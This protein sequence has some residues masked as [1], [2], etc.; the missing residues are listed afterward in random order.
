MGIAVAA[1]AYGTQQRWDEAIEN[2]STSLNPAQTEEKTSAD[3]PQAKSEPASVK[4]DKKTRVETSSLKP[5]KQRVIAKPKS[6]P[7]KVVKKQPT[8]APK[9]AP[10]KTVTPTPTPVATPAPKAIKPPSPPPA[11]L[12]VEFQSNPV[13]ARVRR[14][15]DKKVVGVTPFA[16]QLPGDS[17]TEA[18]EFSLPGY[19]S[20]SQ[21]WNPNKSSRVLATLKAQ[22]KTAPPAQPKASSK[23]AKQ[24]EAKDT[25]H[26]DLVDP[27]AQEEG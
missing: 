2:L 7:A 12:I 16:L 9:A 5:Q 19:E 27:F 8:P 1:I 21:E 3:K 23:P 18:Y 15:A 25:T 11:P 22:V 17:K 4:A 26:E 13:G 20:I 6:K 14:V 24:E 10:V